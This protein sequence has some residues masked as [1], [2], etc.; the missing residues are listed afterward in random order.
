MNYTVY[1]VTSPSNKKYIGITNNF[2]RRMKEHRGS[3]YPFGRALRKYGR[4]NFTYE[5]IPCD[6]IDQAY[7]IESEL[8]GPEEVKSKDYYN[9]SCGGR[10][11]IQFGDN[12]PMKNPEVVKNHTGC[13]TSTNNPMNDPIKKAKMK[14]SMKKLMKAV[15]IKGVEY[16]GVREAGRA[17]NMSRQALGHRLKSPLWPDHIYL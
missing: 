12:N 6:N 5:F 11:D 10:Q 3:K 7:R 14:K 1:I 9:I 4:E 15:S 13:W 17:V 2:K 16:N 8:I